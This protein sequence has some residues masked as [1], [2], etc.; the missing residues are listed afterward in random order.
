MSMGLFTSL[1]TFYILYFVL[2]SVS[3]SPQTQLIHLNWILLLQN[4][5]YLSSLSGIL[6]PGA[7]WMDP[8]FGEGK[9]QLYGALVLVMLAW[10]GWWVERRRVLWAVLFCSGRNK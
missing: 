5:L 1:I 4:M 2:P 6:Y 10:V 3:L 7:G 9:P 8:E